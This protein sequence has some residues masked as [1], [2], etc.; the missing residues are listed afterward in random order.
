MHPF[1]DDVVQFDEP[2]DIVALDVHQGVDP[3][4]GLG[5]ARIDVT[6]LV[7]GPQEPVDAP[8]EDVVGEDLLLDRP[9]SGVED[10]DSIAQAP[11]EAVGP[12][13]EHL[14]QG[15]DAGQAAHEAFVKG[16]ADRAGPGA[17]DPIVL[18]G[19]E[20][21]L[22]EFPIGDQFVEKGAAL[23][24]GD[25]QQGVVVAGAGNV[26]R[27][28]FKRRRAVVFQMD[29][30]V[31]PGFGNGPAV[32][33]PDRFV[34]HSG[35]GVGVDFELGEQVVQEGTLAAAR[36][37]VE[38]I[39]LV[40][41]GTTAQGGHLVDQAVGKEAVGEK[42]VVGAFDKEGGAIVVVKAGR[43]RVLG[44]GL[45]AAVHVGH[46]HVVEDLEDTADQSGRIFGQ[47]PK[48]AVDGDRASPVLN[49]D[50]LV[51]VGQGVVDRVHGPFILPA[52]RMAVG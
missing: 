40:L 16:A 8:L 18:L 26:D 34:A 27:R 7:V 22:L 11:V 20:E 42:G 47:E 5:V 45:R 12:C 30:E 41:L 9:V 25:D 24:L 31:N 49:S 17:K 4:V 15:L 14:V 21:P 44:V 23:R 13:M 48:E 38:D 37:A 32:E 33:A 3:V 35:I 2:L 29:V 46:H 6:D 10:A 28:A 19:V 43:L 39:D 52:L 50:A 1:T 51:E 36:G